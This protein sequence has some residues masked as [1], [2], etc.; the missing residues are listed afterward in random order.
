MANPNIVSVQT[1]RGMTTVRRYVKNFNIPLINNAASSQQII[2][3]NSLYVTHNNSIKDATVNVFISLTTSTGVISIANN[4]SIPVNAT[5]NVLEK[6]RTLYVGEG[7]SLNIRASSNDRIGVVCSYEQI[8]DS[9]PSDRNDDIVEEASPITYPVASGGTEST[10]N[11][12]LGVYKQ[13]VFTSNGTFTVTGGGTFEVLVVGGGGGGGM[14]GGGGGGGGVTIASGIV[15]PGSFSVEVGQGGT[16]QVGWATS[17]DIARK[18]GR[19]SVFN[20]VAHGGGGARSYSSGGAI[21]ENQNV[22]NYGGLGNGQTSYSSVSASFAS[23]SLPSGWTGTIYHQRVGGTGSPSCCPCNG[24]GGA[25]AGTDGVNNNNSNSSSNKPNGGDGVIPIL[26]GVPMYNGQ[27]FW[28]GGGGGADAYC[29]SGAGEAGKG[30]GGGGGD[31]GSG[32]QTNGDIS[33][34][35]PGGNGQP[36]SGGN[37]WGG[38]GGV[39]TGGGGGAGSN[40]NGSTSVRGGTGGSGIVV[41]RYLIG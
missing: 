10:Y 23:N 1:I 39:N 9:F 19:S 28:F 24:G 33:G 25:G 8:S 38:N 16:A 21:A 34:I 27:S 13:H 15:N 14:L 18:G 6:N 20:V 2:K 31:D 40:G 36:Q 29:S 30:G 32:S 26:N 37:G 22:A 12:I 41:I 4:I 11:S 3:V 5:F 17:G 7:E 35:N